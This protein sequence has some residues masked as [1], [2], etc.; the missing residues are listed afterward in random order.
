MWSQWALGTDLLWLGSQA[1]SGDTKPGCIGTAG[2]NTTLFLTGFPA[3]LTWSSRDRSGC[4][5]CAS[6][7]HPFPAQLHGGEKARDRSQGGSSQGWLSLLL[8]EEGKGAHRGTG[9]VIAPPFPSITHAGLGPDFYLPCLP[10]LPPTPAG[11]DR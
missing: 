1:T 2:D 3:L 9:E 10:C 8:G 7:I 4:G 11:S 6:K 5:C